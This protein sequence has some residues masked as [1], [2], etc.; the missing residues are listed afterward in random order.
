[1][2][3]PIE[4]KLLEAADGNAEQIADVKRQLLIVAE[5]MI[6]NEQLD[7]YLPKE[8]LLKSS[9]LGME[10]LF[11][12]LRNRHEWSED[13]LLRTANYRELHIRAYREMLS[14]VKC[15]YRKDP[16]HYLAT[17]KAIEHIIL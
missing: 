12:S 9:L 16:K 14:F 3:L 6:N 5:K 7:Q 17:K 15:A 11:C 8:D 13:T 1:M 4:T 10:D 2:R